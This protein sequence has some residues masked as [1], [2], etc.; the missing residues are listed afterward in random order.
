[1]PRHKADNL[2]ESLVLAARATKPV[3]FNPAKHLAF[4]SPKSILTFQDIGQDNNG[5]SPHAVSEPF[6]L[7]TEEAIMQMR[8]E[9]FREDIL[10]RYYCATGRSSGQVRGHVPN[11]ATFIRD[12]WNSPELLEVVSKVAGV[13]LVPAIDYDIGHANI[14]INADGTEN[15]C[16]APG[17][18]TDASSEYC[19]SAFGW[20]RDSYPFVVVTMLSDCEGMVGGE[21]SIRTG[22]G[23][24]MKARGPARGTAVVMQG[25][26]VDHQATAAKGGR[27]RISMVTSFRPKS[28]QIKDETT[29]RGVRNISDIPTLYTQYTEYKLANLEK[30]VHDELAKLRQSQR[31]AVGFDV[32]QTRDWLTEQRSFLDSMLSELQVH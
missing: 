12:A 3:A 9:I 26:Y 14:M 17:E 6:P 24:I 20:H 7:F 27:E 25:R 28:H 19:E 8:A 2:P 21:T 18:A 30:R 5:I 31:A 29:L 23:E 16:V 11:D 15:D 4:E 13:E 22:S 10:S 1:M 32:A